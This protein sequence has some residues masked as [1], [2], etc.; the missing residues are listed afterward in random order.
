MDN[1]KY[2]DLPRNSRRVF[3]RNSTLGLGVLGLGLPGSAFSAGKEKSSRDGKL[4][5]ALVGL[6]YY[7]REQLAPSLLDTNH[8]YLAGVVTGTEEKAVAMSEQY[9]IPSKNIYN[10]ENMH[11]IADNEEIDIVYIVLP[12]SMHAEYTIKAADAG[13]HVI[14]EKPM[15]ISVSECR[16]MIEAAKKNH[17]SLSIG[18]RLQF[19]P[20]HLQIINYS[21]KETLGK[22]KYISSQFGFVIGDP[23][24][25]R[26]NPELAGGGALM[27]VGIYCIQAARYIFGKE[28]IAVRAQEF[29][30]DPVK[31]SGVD[32]T[33]TWQL[34]FPDGQISNSTTSYNLSTNHLIVSWERGQARLQPAYSYGPLSGEINGEKLD[35]GIYRQ[36]A[37]Q[38][39]AIAMNIKNKEE[40][41]V[42]GEEGL[43]DMMVIAGIYKSLASGGHRITL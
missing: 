11:Q 26:L 39:D 33:V 40:S 28:P 4:G 37:L 32:E 16:Q 14:C 22:P 41:K 18:Y 34:E 31:F 27:D 36:Q 3:I 19:D 1:M 5:V 38:M 29:K 23:A 6:G 10:Y 2:F 17:V 15:A 8:C 13:K 24:Q 12:N 25:W 43:R 30:T 9:G 42:S 20:Y 35:Y 21:R 7:A